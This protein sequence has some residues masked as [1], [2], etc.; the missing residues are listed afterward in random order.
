MLGPNLSSLHV[1]DVDADCKIDPFEQTLIPFDMPT[2]VVA[3]KRI[4]EKQMERGGGHIVLGIMSQKVALSLPAFRKMGLVEFRQA[5]AA[6]LN[7]TWVGDFSDKLLGIPMTTL[8][9]EPVQ[10]QH[11]GSLKSA[12]VA[13]VKGLVMLMVGT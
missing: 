1:I 6:H 4:V 12:Q 3:G 11:L 9:Q 10:S 7:Q 8:M 13:A 5:Y 2:M